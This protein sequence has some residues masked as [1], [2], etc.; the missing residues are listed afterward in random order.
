MIK[1]E[2]NTM[3]LN[4]LKRLAK[5]RAARVEELSIE[6]DVLRQIIRKKAY[7][8][9]SCPHKHADKK[10]LHSTPVADLEKPEKADFET[11]GELE[12]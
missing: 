6:L 5:G 4:Q 8:M 3:D 12:V 9:F 2:W 10:E 7:S 11:K 1:N